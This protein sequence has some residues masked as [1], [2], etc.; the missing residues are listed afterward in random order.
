M[1]KSTKWHSFTYNALYNIF[2]KLT[3]IIFIL[4]GLFQNMGVISLIF[5]KIL[6]ILLTDIHLYIILGQKVSKKA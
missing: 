4:V 1:I 2:V 6:V 3:T 5:S